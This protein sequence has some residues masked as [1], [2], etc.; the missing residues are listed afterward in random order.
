MKQI[1][2]KWHVSDICI[3]LLWKNIT[4]RTV[5]FSNSKRSTPGIIDLEPCEKFWMKVFFAHPKFSEA[6]II[7][8]FWTEFI[9]NYFYEYCY[10][11]RQNI[12]LE[13]GTWLAIIFWGFFFSLLQV[14]LQKVYHLLW[15]VELR[16]FYQISYYFHKTDIILLESG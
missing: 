3:I 15:I 11:F 5:I 9:R 10:N 12:A 1:F 2:I 7:R 16:N 4:T 8:S 6:L 14:F 13:I